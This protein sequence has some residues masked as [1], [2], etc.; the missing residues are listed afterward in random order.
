MAL[1]LARDRRISGHWRRQTGLH[2]PRLGDS[3]PILIGQF[4]CL[5]TWWPRC[6]WPVTLPRRRART[7]IF[8]TTLA[9]ISVLVTALWIGYHLGRR[10][11]S[12]RKRKRRAALGRFA[13]SLIVLVV[14]RHIQRSALRNLP[15]SPSPIIP[16]LPVM[17]AGLCGPLRARA[18]GRRP[19]WR[20]L[21]MPPRRGVRVPTTSACTHRVGRGVRVI[22]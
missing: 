4:S 9:V 2:H 5:N 18:V 8:M 17:V 11:G 15:S 22:G 21:G 3:T 7:L 20:A 14:A 12:T 6:V 13:I 1:R 19:P 10:A 16:S